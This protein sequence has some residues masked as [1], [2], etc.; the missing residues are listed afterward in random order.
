MHIQN[1]YKYLKKNGINLAGSE[2]DIYIN[3]IE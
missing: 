3:R 1:Y 2:L